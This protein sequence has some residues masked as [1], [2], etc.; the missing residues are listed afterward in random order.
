M[1]CTETLKFLTS[2]NFIQLSVRSSCL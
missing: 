1:L 2:R